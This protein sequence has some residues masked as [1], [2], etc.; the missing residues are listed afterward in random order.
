MRAGVVTAVLAAVLAFASVAAAQETGSV[1]GA[2]VDRTGAP[3]AGATVRVSGD[4]LPSERATTTSERG[5]FA[6]LLPPGEYKVIVEK[7]SV[8]T[9]SRTFVV[10][11]GR[12]TE[13][14]FILGALTAPPVAV[15]AD[16]P[17]VD[18]KS[19]E[20]RF[21]YRRAVVQD[22]PL[23][24][25]YRGLTQLIPG[26]AEN[27]GFAPNGGGSRQD[28]AFLLDNVNISNPFFGYLSTEINELD[29]AEFDIKR[30]A[31]R[32]E[33]GRSIGLVTNA[34]I[35]SGTNALSG[36]YRFEAI[37]SQWVQSSTK[38]VR[39]R[40]DRWDHAFDLGGPLVKNRVFFY[41][42]GRI[43]RSSSP[44]AFNI[45]GPLPNRVERIHEFFGKVTARAGTHVFN[46]GYRGRP[47]SIDFAGIGAND[48]PSVASNANG[49]S[50]IGSVSDDWFLDNRTIVSLK[51]TRV[52][53][54]NRTEAVTDLGFLP[55][56]NEDNFHTVGRFVLGGIT[57]GAA[58]LR[59]SRQD[60]SRDEI[61]GS[62]F[63]SFETG[64][65]RHGVKIGGGWD[66]GTE[67]LLRQ[68]NGW[69]DLSFVLVD[70][71]SR[72]RS[73]YYPIQPA[74]RS[75][76]RTVSLFAQDDIAV[77]SR[78]IINA[79]VLANRDSFVQRASG[80]ASSS[81]PV[82]GFI[83]ELQP[84]LGVNLQIRKSTGDKLYVNWARY[85]A[86]DQK[87]GAR[88]VASG[89]LYTVDADFDPATAT[90]ISQVV[91]ANTGAK[92][93]AP[94]LEPPV[95]DEGVV[96][97][98]TPL[99]GGWSLDAFFL[100]RKTRHFIEDVPTVLPFSTFQ[101]QNDPF[102]KRTYRTLTFELKRRLQQG[103]SL[104]LSYAWTA[105]RGNY[106]QDYSTDP[107]GTAFNSSSLVDDGPGAFT[108]DR[109]REGVLSQD[110]PHVYKILGTWTP[111]FAR[112]VSLGVFVRGQ[113]G[114]PWEAR[115]LPW[116]SSVT[117]LRLLEPAGSHRTPFWTN[118]DTLAKYTIALNPRYQLRLE[119]RVLNL[120]NQE[121]TLLVDQRAYLD[122]RNLSIAGSPPQGCW[123]CFTEAYGQGTTQPNANL[124]TPNAYA[125]PRRL[126]LSVLFDF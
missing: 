23:D 124:G 126:L 52:D 91:S 93:V 30:G 50:R 113:S 19:A 90:L 105:L 95:T 17:P 60:Y 40:T 123:S 2:V 110:R 92:T 27:G 55:P 7:T 107:T 69:G 61:R 6:L 5:T 82:F 87:A 54:L 119:G 10:D 99:A 41:G 24:R 16:A 86:L 114:T 118:V 29:I 37:P 38:A 4:A 11:L 83:D 18:L 57:V 28:N 15:T 36:N 47:R 53:E 94:D 104:N 84:R 3:I 51:Y 75:T 117:Y 42:S 45:F 125:Q 20:V 62:L 1:A 73:T 108:S 25:S 32:P 44:D 80:Q 115:A 48:S 112:A 116:A 56:F 122:P 109:N 66:Q 70:G 81:F 64:R 102:A 35:R 8:G 106:D 31:L 98:A 14:D 21:T 85:Y 58:S 78:T 88:A 39:S 43:F 74:Q 101:F 79:G 77:G 120:F 34:V 13:T 111:P 26:V 72:L 59:Q 96:G 121:T 76:G 9:A 100:A 33:Y 46:G 89:R 67:H 97:Y 65:T 71:Q 49:T 12:E 63:R 22:L 103:W 68:T